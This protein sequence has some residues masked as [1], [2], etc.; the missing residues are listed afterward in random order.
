AFLDTGLNVVSAADTAAG[1]L[2]A[3]ERGRTGERYILASENLTLYQ[4]FKT[5]E[6]I[7]GTPAPSVRIPYALAFAVG[8]VTTAWANLSGVVP[9]APLDAVKM[10]RKK[11]W[12]THRKASEELGF[13]PAPA[14][15]ALQQA[16]D[17]FRA[18]GYA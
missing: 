9:L 12:V 1:H 17:W 15:A 5:L 10:A 16:V 8:M 18:N 2:L 3:C 4:I 13:R 14:R 6:K 11:T 7:T